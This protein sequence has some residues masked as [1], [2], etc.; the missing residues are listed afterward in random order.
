[1]ITPL[2]EDLNIIAALDDE[3]ND[4]GGLTPVAFKAKFDEGPNKIKNYLNN[5]MAPNITSDI[6]AAVAA[7]QI[8]SGNM[9]AGGTAGQVLVKNSGVDYD[10]GWGTTV[11]DPVEPGDIANKGYVDSA[12]SNASPVGTIELGVINPFG[13]NGLLCNGADVDESQ[14]PTL[15]SSLTPTPAGQ[16]SYN[17]NMNAG[18]TNFACDGNYIV[19]VT[20]SQVSYML[21]SSFKTGTW[22]NLNVGSQVFRSVAYG[23]GYW[24]AVGDNGQLYTA[25]DPTGTWTARNQNS[26]Y[27][28]LSVA[29]ANGYWVIAGNLSASG[30]MWYQPSI[31]TGTWTQSSSYGHAFACAKYLN[32]YWVVTTQAAYIYYGINLASTF[33]SVQVAVGINLWGGVPYYENGYYTVFQN[34]GSTLYYS[35]NLISWSPR[36]VTNGQY[37]VYWN[38]IWIACNSS[39]M[40]AYNTNANPGSESWVYNTQTS[41][42]SFRGFF[43]VGNYLIIIDQNGRL[44]YRDKC[45]PTLASPTVG[46]NYYIKVL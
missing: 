43:T 26:S 24:V 2:N 27:Q 28:F 23:N 45:L 34:G 3:P 25:T 11:A 19:T 13:I 39:G 12:I 10:Y 30:Y 31:P 29:Y 33:S 32:N 41:N 40:M 22:T 36:T 46:T 16:W 15:Y 38:N 17:S 20:N 35:T 9:P 7:V 4:E 42:F 14:Y 5:T 6:T 8:Q 21:A 1:M 18:L 44:A 37:L